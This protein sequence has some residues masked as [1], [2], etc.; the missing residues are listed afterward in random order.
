MHKYILLFLAF[1][2]SHFSYSQNISVKSF[3]II[4]NNM[5]ARVNYA[6]MDQNGDKCAI[7]KIVS[8][9]NDFVF[10]GDQLGIVTTERKTGE[11]WLYVPR[12]VKRLTIKHDKLGVLR[13]YFYPMAIKEATVYEMVL[14]TAK[15]TTLVEEI[16]TPMQWLAIESNPSGA[17]VYIN[18]QYVGVSPYS[19]K[20][21]VGSYTYRIEKSMYHSEAGKVQLDEQGTKNLSLTL[22]PNFGYVSITTLPE[23]GASIELDGKE[24]NGKSPYKSEALLSGTHKLVV[25]KIMF[26][27]VSK[28]FTVKDGETTD[29]RIELKPN[30][31]QVRV[32]ANAGASIYIDDEKKGTGTYTGRLMPGLHTFEARLESYT[33]DK[34]QLEVVAGEEKTIRLQALAKTGNLD[35][36]S[37]PF[38]ATIKLNGMEKGKTPATLKNL[39]VGTYTLSLEKENH[40]SVSKTIT[41]SEN[42][43]TEIN[44]TLPS[45]KLV[46]ITSEPSGADLYVNGTYVGK[47][48][49]KKTMAFGEQQLKL[50]NGE[51][52]VEDNIRVAQDGKEE[53]GFNFAKLPLKGAFIDKRD[54]KTY[55]YVTIGNQTWMA[56]NLA[57]K[58]ASGNYW[59]YEN[60]ESNVEKYGY[61]YDWE[62]AIKV[63]P[64]GWHLPS[65]QEWKKLIDFIASEGYK[66][67]EGKALKSKSDWVMNGKGTDIYGFNAFPGGSRNDSNGSFYDSGYIGCWWSSTEYASLYA[68][69]RR[70]SYLS[71]AVSRSYSFK[72]IGHSVRCVKD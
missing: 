57:Y 46:N 14:T 23:N 51:K 35:V 44:E 32:E 22:K 29:L 10:E 43:N 42:K 38:G 60:K 6:K 41:I 72:S 53:W 4:P 58:P 27:P 16:E 2:F 54:N 8:P 69:Y 9:I 56:E 26:T 62:T 34:K 61:L 30:F 48:P 70:L 1:A 67:Q 36:T 21:E 18:E 15:V 50:V 25:K 59:T 19:K 33:S 47:T 31:A 66:G 24:I 64:S 20:M 28:E 63:C 55:K 11:Y 45:G 17:D 39:L 49:Y 40:G 71:S 3:R 37:T 12:G 52:S 13:D 65:N 5:D 7:I 68:Y